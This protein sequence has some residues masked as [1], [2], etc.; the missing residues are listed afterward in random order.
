VVAQSW[1]KEDTFCICN[2]L[3]TIRSNPRYLED[4]TIRIACSSSNFIVLLD[5]S[6]LFDVPVDTAVVVSSLS[7]D[8]F[9]FVSAVQHCL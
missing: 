7:D 8:I 6:F 2:I 3:Q 1:E 4:A 9:V 5:V